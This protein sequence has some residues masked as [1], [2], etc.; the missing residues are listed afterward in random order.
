M[1]ATTNCEDGFVSETKSRAHVREKSTLSGGGSDPRLLRWLP[2][3]VVNDAKKAG[4]KET[5]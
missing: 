4:V 5:V 2:P 1:C 3:V